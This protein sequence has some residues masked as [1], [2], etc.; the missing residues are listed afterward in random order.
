MEDLK[1]KTIDYLT[2]I[3]CTGKTA[4]GVRIWKCRCRCGNEKEVTE[5]S[6]RN[7]KHFH[8]CGCF[9]RQYL[10]PGTSELCRKAGKFRAAQR[11]KDGVN[12]EMLDGSRN[13]TTNTSG[14]KGVT[15]SKAARKWH[16]FI[17]YKGYRCNLGY[18]A[19]FDEASKLRDAAY[20]A[21]M[22]GTFED[23]FYSIRGFRIED[24]LTQNLKKQE[25]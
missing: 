1:G 15:W 13:I 7:T 2:V 9:Q 23:F 14:K 12:M 6:L 4:Y 10:R 3:S 20:N 22:N 11:N 25:S 17:G 19:D 24:K 21:V 18:L 5:T 8:S 16:V